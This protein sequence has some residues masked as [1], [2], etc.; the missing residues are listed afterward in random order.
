M[1]ANTNENTTPIC[2]ECGCTDEELF[3]LYIDGEYKLVCADCAESNGYTRCE[4][5]GEWVREDELVPVN[6]PYPETFY[7][8]ESCA[9]RNYY[10]CDDCGEYFTYDYIHTD[11][12]GNVVCNSCY[13]NHDYTTCDDCGCITRDY[14]YNDDDDCYYC[15]DCA[16]SHHRR[17]RLHDYSYK[18]SPE[19]QF[20]SAE[21]TTAS[22][23][24]VSTLDSYLTF[25]VELEVDDGEDASDLCEALD[26]LELPIYMKHDG[27]LHSEGVEIVTHPGSL[28]WHMND[29]P[30]GDVANTCTDNGYKSHNTSTCG[31]HIHVG[32][33]GMG[34]DGESRDRTAANLVIL[35]DALWSE[36]VKFTRRKPDA[37]SRWAEKPELRSEITVGSYWNRSTVTLDLT[38][39]ADLIRSALHTRESGRYQ[40]VNLTNSH[41]VEFRIFRGTLKRDTLI[42]SIQ[43]VNNLTRY[44]MTHT[45]T[46]C[47]NAKWADIIAV[48]PF[49]ELTTYCQTRELL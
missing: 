23:A 46:E 3:E 33:R 1:N 27:S 43:V 40:A 39:D 30:W 24:G 15:S 22:N 44:A 32:R 12:D 41:T 38:N 37:L 49:Q 19:F 21:R 36:L 31:L 8:C 48:D 5:C 2:A 35:T 47:R 14:E 18:P 42:A 16:S 4:Y 11:N 13:D 7:V 17:G 45:P 29:M 20:T 10:L 25:G 9:E 26:D 34:S 6:N 28:A